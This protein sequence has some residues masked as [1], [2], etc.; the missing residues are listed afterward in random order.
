MRT[1]LED[2]NAWILLLSG[3]HPRMLDNQSA[4]RCVRSQAY[5]HTWLADALG[6][7]YLHL[8]PH[9]SKFPDCLWFTHLLWHELNGEIV[10]WVLFQSRVAAKR[11]IDTRLNGNLLR[12]ELRLR[13]R[14]HLFLDH[15]RQ[16]DLHLSAKHR[17]HST[18]NRLPINDARDTS[19]LGLVEQGRRSKG[20][21]QK[22]SKI[23]W[24]FTRCYG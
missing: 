7:L 5:L 19:V 18:W 23:Q 3:N 21:F 14:L 22:N 13:A 6:L 8:L 12:R 15:K 17:S 4:G 9:D 20:R 10:R 24:Y 2:W 16:L 1:K 11:K